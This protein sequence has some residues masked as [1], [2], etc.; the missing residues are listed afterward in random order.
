MPEKGVFVDTLTIPNVILEIEEGN[1]TLTQWYTAG[2]DA[3]LI[4]YQFNGT[5]HWFKDSTYSME[6]DSSLFIII[7]SDL[8]LVEGREPE[9]ELRNQGI[10]QYNDATKWILQGALIQQ[11]NG[12]SFTTVERLDLEKLQIL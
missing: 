7:D 2:S 1:A 8:Y 3:N 6:I 12:K 9:T 11:Q 10:L 5:L 4:F